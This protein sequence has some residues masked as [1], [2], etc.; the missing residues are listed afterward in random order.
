[1]VSPKNGK[2]AQVA[3]AATPTPPPPPTATPLPP[4]PT[5][6]PDPITV[7]ISIG[8]D[9][10]KG[11]WVTIWVDD[12]QKVAKMAAPGETFNFQGRKVAIRAGRPNNVSVKVNGQDKV[13]V[14]PN[15]GIITHTYYA[16]GHD[17]VEQ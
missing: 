11:S 8:T 16:D 2:P 14:Q 5:P 17:T 9:D 6:L 12:Q 10:P 15:A 4:T 1:V 3:P 7:D 13:Y